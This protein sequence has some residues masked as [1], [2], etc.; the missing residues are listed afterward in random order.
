LGLEARGLKL[1]STPCAPYDPGHPIRSMTRSPRRSIIFPNTS[2]EPPLRVNAR[3]VARPSTH[4]GYWAGMARFCREFFGETGR[5]N[6]IRRFGF[7]ACGCWQMKLERRNGHESM[8]ISLHTP[9]PSRAY[10]AMICGLRFAIRPAK[11]I[12]TNPQTGRSVRNP[13]RRNWLTT[14]TA[15]GADY[16]RAFVRR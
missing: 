12:W 2:G 7:Q 15:Y 9:A 11:D 8:P 13:G 4:P 14:A 6:R 16:L 3:V 10:A 5:P 1:E